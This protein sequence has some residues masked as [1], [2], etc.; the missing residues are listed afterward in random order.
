MGE[1]EKQAGFGDSDFLLRSSEVRDLEPNDRGDFSSGSC[2][3]GGEITHVG[4][5]FAA[6]VV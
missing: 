4:D 1:G 2:S 5:L 6:V 3:G